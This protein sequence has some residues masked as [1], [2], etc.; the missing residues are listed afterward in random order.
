MAYYFTCGPQS[1]SYSEMRPAETFSIQMWPVNEFEFKTPVLN[2]MKN[3]FELLTYLIYVHVNA[4]LL[5]FCLLILSLF[6]DKP[7]CFSD[8]HADEKY[9]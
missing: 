6:S 1:P 9:S 7:C 4:P 2:D 3:F 5:V 8:D